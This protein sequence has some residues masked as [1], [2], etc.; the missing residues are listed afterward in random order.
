M[1]TTNNRARRTTD[2][3]RNKSHCTLQI[4]RRDDRPRPQKRAYLHLPFD[5]ASNRTKRTQEGK[6]L[7]AAGTLN[8]AAE[9]ARVSASPLGARA[10]PITRAC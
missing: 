3:Y 1:L 6:L 5:Y 4:T 10:A 2:F 9:D 7:P 8:P